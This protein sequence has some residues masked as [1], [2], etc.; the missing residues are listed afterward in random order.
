M[1][2]QIALTAAGATSFALVA[3]AAYAQP[4]N[5]YYNAV[6]VSAPTVGKSMIRGQVWTCDGQSCFAGQGE[7]RPAIICAVAARELGKLSAFTANGE[8]LDPASLE[9]CNARAK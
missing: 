2:R 6:P 9:K 1:F 3:S 5:A 4:S 7:S 8:A